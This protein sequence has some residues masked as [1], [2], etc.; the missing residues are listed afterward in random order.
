MNSKP[1]VS[2]IMCAYNEEPL[3]LREAIESVLNQTYRDFEVIITLDNPDNFELDEIILAYSTKDARIVYIK[4]EKNLGLVTCLNNELALSKGKYIA[5]MDAD[6]ICMLNRFQLQMD[7]MLENPSVD[8]VGTN[9]MIIDEASDVLPGHNNAPSSY[10]F[11]KRA[12]KY[13]SVIVHPT[14]MFKREVAMN[15]KIKGYRE[16]LLAEDYDFVCRLITNNFVVT[17]MKES[18]LK[19]RIRS[20][21]VTRSNS[22]YQMKI[23]SYVIKMYKDRLKYGKDDFSKAYIKSLELTQKENK[24]FELSKTI[25]KKAIYYKNKKWFL[26]YSLLFLVSKCVNKDL[27]LNSFRNTIYKLIYK[28]YN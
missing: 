16:V 11:I 1:S 8:L 3:W 10:K 5:R 18:L 7:F 6:D 24:M 25:A 12:M 20:T 15:Y 22:L 13:R 17:N 28:V 27:L 14:L 21:S 23:K 2:V 26:H 4:N 19:Y 9:I